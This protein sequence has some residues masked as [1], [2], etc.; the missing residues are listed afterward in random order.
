MSNDDNKLCNRSI[1]LNFSISAETDL[2][3]PIDDDLFLIKF[4]RPCKFYPESA[5][6][7]VLF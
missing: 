7:K 3:V 4:L 6:D 2:Y 1:E 5:L